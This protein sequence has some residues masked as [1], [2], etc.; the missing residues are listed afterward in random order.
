MK[1]LI[2]IPADDHG[3]CEYSALTF[4]VYLQ[5][6][7]N[8]NVAV[9]FPVHRKTQY[10]AY[11]AGIN[12][13]RCLP[14]QVPFPASD[15]EEKVREQQGETWRVLD[16]V[17]PDLVFIAMPWPKRGQGMIT[18]CMGV[19]VPTL[20]K[21]ALVP[22]QWTESDY[23]HP[24][25]RSAQDSRQLWFVSSG[26]SA[27]LLEQ[28]FGLGKGTVDHFLE[29]PVGVQTLLQGWRTR[30]QLPRQS[31]RSRDEVFGFSTS[32]R[33]IVTTVSRLTQQKG[34]RTLVQA[35][36]EV[37]KAAPHVHFVWVGEGEER[38]TL[39]RRINEA[40]LTGAVSL[41]GFRT[42]V[43][44]ILR[45]SDAFVLPTHY[46]GG[47]SQ[48]LLEAMEETLPVVATNTS[49]I[50]EV[51]RHGENGLLAKV[52]DPRALAAGILSLVKSPDLRGKLAQNA[53]TSVQS[54]S[55]D[56][57]LEHTFRRLLRLWGRRI[58]PDVSPP[59]NSLEAFAF[60]DREAELSLDGPAFQYGWWGTERRP[61][62]L[63][64]RWAKKFSALYVPPELA[65]RADSL[66]IAGR[67]VI[68][69][70][71]V[72]EMRVLMNQ[73]PASPRVQ[74]SGPR[75]AWKASV[76]VPRDTDRERGLLIQIEAGDEA[77]IGRLFSQSYLGRYGSFSVRKLA[78]KLLAKR[79]AP[80][81]PA[82]Q[83]PPSSP[84]SPAEE[85][86]SPGPG[87][88]SSLAQVPHGE[89][90][91]P[92]PNFLIIGVQKGGTTWLHNRLA[93]HPEV[94]MS[95]PKELN[96]F[97]GEQRDLDQDSIHAYFEQFSAGQG[98]AVCGESSVN[99]FWNQDPG[100]HPVLA[101]R[102]NIPRHVRVVLG[103]QVR[104]ALILRHPVSR[105]ISAFFHHF[106]MGRI[107][108]TETILE[109]AA[110][111]LGIVG[112]GRYDQQWPLW[113][114]QFPREQ[115]FVGFYDD[116]SLRPE[117]L[118]HA[119]TEWLGIRGVGT[120]LPTRERTP[121]D[122]LGFVTRVGPRG[123]EVVTNHERSASHLTRGSVQGRLPPAVTFE[124]IAN[125]GS[126]FVET[127]RFVESEFGWREWS[128]RYD[129][130]TYVRAL[131]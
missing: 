11:L 34:Y 32:D 112:F 14:F 119:V 36:P 109:A 126:L 10:L 108:E 113:L 19:G 93:E 80:A 25:I 96:H 12:G 39:T 125:L 99:Y 28:H 57:M 56:V 73:Q 53:K 30:G 13:L 40:G 110:R 94:F 121:K 7:R 1:C 55:L 27:A 91:S 9:T 68:S 97:T 38:D 81:N 8:W 98:R 63:C 62:G 15:N 66:F 79:A 21:V 22:E 65:S 86:A 107:A 124:E 64:H 24:M 71:A 72:Q 118:V 35:I 48:V 23:V 43:R 54:Y 100:A 89:R 84:A 67:N 87:S 41:L 42:D 51:I 50:H 127:L 74:C 26:R 58:E 106:L 128:G 114:E 105:A 16:E 117:H 5:E 123:I 102:V 3:G 45:H 95:T 44:D 82:P 75:G 37:V 129:P 115:V 70:K 103:D 4:G 49:A 78:F 85:P 29:G 31:A 52:K 88:P 60:V 20:V 77:D 83:V 101:Q 6:A 46:E 17:R 120:R 61:D 59:S 33:F 92:R 76:A 131:K 116:L 69:P 47:C 18:G 104:L 130:E 90:P 2:M 122:N 111:P